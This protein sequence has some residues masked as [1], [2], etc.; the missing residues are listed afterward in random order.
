MASAYVYIGVTALLVGSLT[1]LFHTEEGGMNEALQVLRVVVIL[2][3]T[4][5]LVGG[6]DG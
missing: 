2:A 1:G 6:T 3:G 5:M 4:G